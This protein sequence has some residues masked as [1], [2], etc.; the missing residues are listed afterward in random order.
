MSVG[1]ANGDIKE[2][3]SRFTVGSGIKLGKGLL[4]EIELDKLVDELGFDETDRPYR[5]NS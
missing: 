5:T 4:I 2:T 1:E 3:F